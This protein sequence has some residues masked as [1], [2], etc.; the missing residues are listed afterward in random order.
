[1]TESMRTRKGLHPGRSSGT[2]GPHGPSSQM[3]LLQQEGVFQRVAEAPKGTLPRDGHG[4]AMGF[5]GVSGLLG[6]MSFP[7]FG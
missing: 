7:G 5:E 6:S 1:M 4:V 2:A 3:P